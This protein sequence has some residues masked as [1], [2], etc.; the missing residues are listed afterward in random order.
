LDLMGEVEETPADDEDILDLMDEVEETPADDEEM[1]DLTDT[2]I[3]THITEDEIID[4]EE[5]GDIAMETPTDNEEI[6]ELTEI[7]DDALAVS[8]ELSSQKDGDQEQDTNYADSLGIE[9]GEDMKRKEPEIASPEP[10]ESTEAGSQEDLHNQN[11]E[12][13]QIT[14]IQLEETLEK[15][16]RKM[17]SEKIDSILVDVIEKTVSEEIQ[18]LKDILTEDVKDS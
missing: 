10:I 13:T 17:F 5:A 11:I 7:D 4:L 9:L 18:R 15:V 14:Q 8:I 12:G 2:V 1:I 3:E 16:I 6:I